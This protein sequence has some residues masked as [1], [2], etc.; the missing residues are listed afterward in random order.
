MDGTKNIKHRK[1]TETRKP[2]TLNPVVTFFSI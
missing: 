1:K 2:E